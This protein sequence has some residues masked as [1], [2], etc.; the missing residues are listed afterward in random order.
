M[1]DSA[2]NLLITGTQYGANAALTGLR[3]ASNFITMPAAPNPLATTPGMNTAQY[4]INNSAT[5]VH[6]LLLQAQAASG[7]FFGGAPGVSANDYQRALRE[8]ADLDRARYLSSLARN[9][10]LPYNAMATGGF[11]LS[12]IDSVASL[13]GGTPGGVSRAATAL[14][15][16]GGAFSLMSSAASVM[17]KDMLVS[18][19]VRAADRSR[20]AYMNLDQG[21]FSSVVSGLTSIRQDE[22]TLLNRRQLQRFKQHGIENFYTGGIVSQGISSTI[23]ASL[24][25]PEDFL[26]QTATRSAIARQAHTFSRFNPAAVGQRGFRTRDFDEIYDELGKVAESTEDMTLS[27]VVNQFTHNLAAGQYSSSR[28]LSDF[29]KRVQD[30]KSQLEFI[31]EIGK[32]TGESAN[33]IRQDMQRVQQELGISSPAA[34]TAYRL[35]SQQA[36][37]LSGLGQRGILQIGAAGAQAF[38]KVGFSSDYGF[39]SGQRMGTLSG[40]LHQRGDFMSDKQWEQVGGVQGFAA[41]M[42]QASVATLQS[43]LGS[44]VVAGLSTMDAEGNLRI[45]SSRLKA[46]QA[47]RLSIDQLTKHSSNLI[48]QPGRSAENQL[49]VLSQLRNLA[50]EM[51]ADEALMYTAKAVEE[52]VY[53]V[54]PN[55]KGRTDEQSRQAVA[56][57]VSEQLRGMG[58]QVNTTQALGLLE[59]SGARAAYTV[60]QE[61]WLQIN[62]RKAMRAQATESNTFGILR[63]MFDEDTLRERDAARRSS[64]ITENILGSVNF[65]PDTGLRTYRGGLVG[66]SETERNERVASSRGVGL[67]TL[68]ATGVATAQMTLG[69]GLLAASA[70]GVA[71][72]A[73]LY[74]PVAAYNYYQ[75][76]SD[77]DYDI[78]KGL[79]RQQLEDFR[80]EKMYQLELAGISKDDSRLYVDD[81]GALQRAVRDGTIEADEDF[82]KRFMDSTVS[83]VDLTPTSLQSHIRDGSIWDMS[84]EAIMSRRP[85]IGDIAYDTVGGFGRRVATVAGVGALAK[86]TGFAATAGAKFAGAGLLGKGLGALGTGATAVGA[87]ALSPIVLGTAAIAATAYGGH[88]LYRSYRASADELRGEALEEALRATAV[89]RGFEIDGWFDGWFGGSTN[90]D[91]TNEDD[92]RKIFAGFASDERREKTLRDY[93]HRL[94]MSDEDRL[95]TALDVVTGQP[96]V[97]AEEAFDELLSGRVS[98]FELLGQKGTFRSITDSSKTR[99]LEATSRGYGSILSSG[100]LSMTDKTANIENILGDPTKTQGLQQSLMGI[101]KYQAAYKAAGGDSLKQEKALSVLKHNYG[102]HLAAI[103]ISADTITPDLLT[104]VDT[105]WNVEIEN[106]SDSLAG[107]EIMDLLSMRLGRAKGAAAAEDDDSMFKALSNALGQETSGGG[108]QALR[109]AFAEGG[110]SGGVDHLARLVTDVAGEG[111]WG[112]QRARVRDFLIKSKVSDPSLLLDR[113]ES[114]RRQGAF[115][116]KSLSH[117]VSKLLVKETAASAELQKTQEAGMPSGSAAGAPMSRDLL[118]NLTQ[119]INGLVGVKSHFEEALSATGNQVPQN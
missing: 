13:V 114:L 36:G 92:I 51:P 22:N 28:D 62:Q 109:S 74:A 112:E 90:I 101:A 20:D 72:G 99:I 4:L 103:G 80:R 104:K 35:G 26:Q 70:K 3:D 113:A 76:S 52:Q 118:E 7:M 107:V 68:A 115:G 85:S 53:A 12:S 73:A 84:D 43:G 16:V 119:A 61:N 106:L 46:L 79:R 93:G 8:R 60:E 64:S 57:G 21:L 2:G 105:S 49:R 5:S 96:G 42:L 38:S 78:R 37:A 31:K 67:A 18:P 25:L 39:I 54:A 87:A 91:W 10:D 69:A 71:V 88:R 40:M 110:L 58:I 15:G 1:F 56:M 24:G 47:G 100:L 29:K 50:E 17:L 19:L 95:K 81:I 63:R 102:Q 98:L 59:M 65:I 55:L 30:I 44:T 86:I 9:V 41:N 89:E 27:D 75:R 83:L 34:F 108:A 33:E 48:H 6:P 82:V 117:I 97:D 11:A 32:T 66:E 111:E 94:Y 77:P 14:P 23:R 116:G 45:D